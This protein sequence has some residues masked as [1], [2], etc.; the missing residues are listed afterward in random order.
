MVFMVGMTLTA[1]VMLVFSANTATPVRWVS[2]FLL[3]MGLMM[4]VEAFRSLGKPNVPPED[5]VFRSELG[6]PAVATG[7]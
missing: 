1:T 5:V 2:A 6:S 3:V 4:A 7:D